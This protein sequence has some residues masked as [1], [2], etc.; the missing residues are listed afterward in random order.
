MGVLYFCRTLAEL[1][2]ISDIPKINGSD[3]NGHLYA[4]HLQ[5]LDCLYETNK[6]DRAIDLMDLICPVL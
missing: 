2:C 5:V 6:T 3:G 1:D 4:L